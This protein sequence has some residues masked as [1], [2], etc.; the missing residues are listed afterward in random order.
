MTDDKASPNNPHAEAIEYL[1]DA[2]K[3]E[4]SRKYPTIRKVFLK[5]YI[6]IPSSAPVEWLFSLGGL[7]LTP[8]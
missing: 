6:T 1:R 8:K 5:Y 2:K 3:L 7:V 4:C